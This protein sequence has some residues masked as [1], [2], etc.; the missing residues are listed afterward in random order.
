MA[1]AST[2][3]SSASAG[4]ESNAVGAAIKRASKTIRPKPKKIKPDSL[5][6]V[7]GPTDGTGTGT[8]TE[9]LCESQGGEVY[10]EPAS[11]LESDP[12]PTYCDPE[13][14]VK[15]QI[16]R[17]VSL[18]FYKITKGIVVAQLLRNELAK[19]VEGRCS[20]EGYICPDTVAISSY[21]C[22]TLAG[23]NIHFDI[24]AD[25]L[26]CYPDENSVITCVAKTITQAG[27]RAGAKDLER[28]KVSP[29]EVFLSRDMHASSRDLFSRIEEND[30]LTVKIIGRR[31][32]LH[33]THI[34]IIAMLLDVKKEYKV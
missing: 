25:C 15:R 7:S 2:E 22:G 12:K 6:Q 13:L 9:P 23:A 32:V 19:M 24:I 11:E 26:I 33:D 5:S 34:T 4:F 17:T 16:R 3:S 1:S 31:F 28:G 21:S 14:F 29:I 27:V 30:I 10:K 20:I 18:P 8:G